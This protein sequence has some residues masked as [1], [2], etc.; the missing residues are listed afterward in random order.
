MEGFEKEGEILS[1]SLF[2]IMEELLGTTI[3]KVKEG[4]L[5]QLINKISN[6]DPTTH[7]LYVDYPIL[8]GSLYETINLF[9]L[10]IFTI[11]G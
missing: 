3:E 8:C 1:P 10:K 7:Q 4:G 9:V 11:M 6:I 5:F 2:I